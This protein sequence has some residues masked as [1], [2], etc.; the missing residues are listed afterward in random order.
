MPHLMSTP[1]VEDTNSVLTSECMDATSITWL[2]SRELITKNVT[3]GVA[4]E[5]TCFARTTVPSARTT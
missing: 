2:G 4:F 3:A 1:S 5:R